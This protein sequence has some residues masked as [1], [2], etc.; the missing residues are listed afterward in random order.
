VKVGDL[1]RVKDL[2]P[3]LG[4]VVVAGNETC[5]KVKWF[6]LTPKCIRSLWHIRRLEVLSESR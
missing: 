4:V 6:P 3:T 1:V 5:V 2:A